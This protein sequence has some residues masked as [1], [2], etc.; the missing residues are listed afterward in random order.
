MCLQFALFVFYV[1]AS[2]INKEATDWKFTFQCPDNSI[3]CIDLKKTN[4][5]GWLMFTI[6]ILCFMGPDIAMSMKQLNQGIVRRDATLLASGIMLLF[7]SIFAIYSSFVYNR[8]LAEKNTDLILNAVVLI[9]IME[10]DDQIHTIFKKLFP[11]WTKTIE[12]DIES[13]MN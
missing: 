10:L 3:D 2:D 7:L 8:A 4:T 6:V 13:K 5:R 1:Q 9:F 11:K 12:Q